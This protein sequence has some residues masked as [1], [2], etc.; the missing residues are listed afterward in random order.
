[1]DSHEIAYDLARQFARSGG[2]LG[3]RLYAEANWRK[4]RREELGT[5]RN[6]DGVYLCSAVDG[7]KLLD[8]VP[9]V[10]TAVIPNGAAVARH[11]RPDLTEPTTR[12]RRSVE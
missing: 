4:L 8:Q 9:D 12:S 3:R 6:A 5:Y 1:V 7:R 2:N 10:R 11:E